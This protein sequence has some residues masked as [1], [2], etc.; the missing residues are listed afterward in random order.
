[1]LSNVHKPK[2]NDLIIECFRQCRILIDYLHSNKNNGTV[3]QNITTFFKNAINVLYILDVNSTSKLYRKRELAQSS[4]KVK[5]IPCLN[6]NVPIDDTLS[7]YPKI[8]VVLQ[9]SPYFYF[10]H[11][12]YYLNSIQS[13]LDIHKEI[14]QLHPISIVDLLFDRYA[15]YDFLNKFITNSKTEIE[16]LNI[17]VS[18][19]FS[20]KYTIDVV[21]SRK[22][23]CDI[24][25]EMIKDKFTY[26]F[27]IKPVSCAQH[28]M[29]LIVNEKGIDS[30]FIN[31]DKYK[32]FFLSNASFIIQ[33][34][35]SHGGI[36][37]KNYSI[38]EESYSFIRPS[39]PDMK[40]EVLNIKDL[41][42][43]SMSFYNEL[44][45][46]KKIDNFFNDSDSTKQNELQA[47]LTSQMEKINQLS[48]LFVK[49]TKITFYG[50]DFLFDSDKNLFY[51]L[52]INYFPSY[53]ELG[54]QLHVKFDEHIVKYHSKYK[55]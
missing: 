40:G 47:K 14:V 49:E 2:L 4:Q 17:N 43:G 53:R 9:R 12:D 29:E 25:K 16:K 50:L 44:I 51:I 42:D 20:I 45:Y 46:Q 24:L 27:I 15:V 35:I 10:E 37:I 41:S 31:E 30:L 7:V 36:M 8:D 3:Q 11:R 28:E 38:N 52:E 26:P 1:M 55:N 54:S 48:L 21:K 39:L 6:K 33:Q 13:K 22:E 19:P 34:F 5:Y 18:I 23:N 32:K